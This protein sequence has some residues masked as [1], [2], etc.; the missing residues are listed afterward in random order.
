MR[1]LFA[2][3][4]ALVAALFSLSAVAG[5][6]R[7]PIELSVNVTQ[8]RQ[9]I[10][11]VTERIPVTPGPLTLYYPKWIPG[12]HSAAGPIG[13]MAGLFFKAGGK[14]LAWQRDPVDVYTFHVDVPKGVHMLTVS[15]DLL[16]SRSHVTLTP[17]LVVLEWNEVALYPAGLPTKDI[18]FH[19]QITLPRGWRYAT[20]LV[21]VSNAGSTYKFAPV[22]FNNLV[23]SPLMAGEYFREVNLSPGNPVHHYLD[24]VA[25][26]PQD[27][28]ISSATVH[29]MRNLIVQANRLF[30][31]HHYKN[32]RFL[33][34]LSDYTRGGGGGLEHHQS[35]DNRLF[36]NLLVNK[37]VLL[38]EASLM[39]HEYVHSWN[40]KFRRPAKLWQPNF[41]IPERTRMLWVYEGL[42]NYWG[43]VLAARSGLFDPS[44]YR[45]MLAYTAAG[46]DHRPGR[47]WRPLIDTTVGEPMGGYGVDYG[48]WRRGGD[49]Y[50]EGVLIWLGVDVKIREL[51][52][53][54]RSLDDFA[55]RFYGMDNGSYVTNTYTFDDVVKALNSVAPYDWAS[56]LHGLLDKTSDHAPLKGLVGAGWKLV[57]SDKPNPYEEA[58]GVIHHFS[59]TLFSIGL[60]VDGDGDINN[61]LW[62][63]PAFKA[64]LAQGM[65]IVSV[66]GLTFSP[67]VFLQAVADSSKPGHSKLVIVASG[68]GL[69]NTYTINYTGGLRYAHLQRVNGAPNYLKDII[70]P[71]KK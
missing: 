5:Y 53:N 1:I 34:S 8:P 25:D 63:G 39:S 22:T 43:E 67:K 56:Y 6:A 68:S 40:G 30:G 35:S 32:Y 4:S 10:F 15:F 64:G 62:N 50:D 12:E 11:Y 7:A 9:H 3:G 17:D 46:M 33:L 41:Q 49:Y 59:R 18:D 55:K 23:D 37:Q 45:A 14:T 70:A 54:R 31:A 13:N 26:R 61:E 19:P 28:D 66:N 2:C 47:Q 58:R 60:T 20:A 69:T 44:Q 16:P 24:M 21:T 29:G 38:G 57:Y 48:N 27:L 51:T 42:T 36:A 71:V 65:K 52:H